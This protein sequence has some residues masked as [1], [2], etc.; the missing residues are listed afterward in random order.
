MAIYSL[1]E[2]YY[3]GSNGLADTIIYFLAFS[4]VVIAISLLFGA[5]RGGLNKLYKQVKND[6]WDFVARIVHFLTFIV[7][8]GQLL[9]HL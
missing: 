2:N 8:L 4:S 5:L 9:P 1:L 3:W 7:L 6:H